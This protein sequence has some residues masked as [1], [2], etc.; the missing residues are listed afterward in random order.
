MLPPEELLVVLFFG[1]PLYFMLA[2]DELSALSDS[3]A[4]TFK[5]EADDAFA[6]T[7]FTIRFWAL[8]LAALDELNEAELEFPEILVVLPLVV[9]QE[10]LSAVKLSFKLA[11]EEF[12]TIILSFAL[13]SPLMLEPEDELMV[14][15]FP[16]ISLIVIKVEPVEVFTE[17]NSGACT[18]TK[19]FLKFKVFLSLFF[20]QI[21]RISPSTSVLIYFC[22]S[23]SVS[24]ITY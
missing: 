19:I 8:Q 22:L 10:I 4:F 6:V 17:F 3:V 23:E 2:P 5:V 12:P 7:L 20:I 11:P 24:T 1:F 21:F 15:L 14:K 18:L 13:N 16:F 9:S